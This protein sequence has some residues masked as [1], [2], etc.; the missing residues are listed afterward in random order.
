MAG[1]APTRYRYDVFL[2][3]SS[4][5]KPVVRELAEQLRAAGLR[6]WFDEWVIKPGD[7]ISVKIE[8]GLEHSAVLLFC[9]SANAIGSD[10]V[11][12]EHHAAIFRD[13]QNLERRFVPLRLDDVKPKAMLRIFAEVD[14]RPGADRELE[15]GRLLEACGVEKG[16]R[17]GEQGPAAAGAPAAGAAWEPPPRGPAQPRQASG[18]DPE[19]ADPPP[20][21]E[22]AQP[23]RAPAKPPTAP[24]SALPQHT[25]ALQLLHPGPALSVGWSPDGARLLSGGEDG[26]V[27]LWEAASGRELAV[28]E[29][30]K[31]WV[32]S[33][34]WSPDG[35]RLLS[36][37]EDGTVR[38]WEAASGRELAVLEGHKWSVWS[39]GWSPDGAR[40]LSGGADGTVRL[41]EAASGRELA[42]LEGHTEPVLS[43]GWS[44]DGGLWAAGAFGLVLLWPADL[45]A[46]PPAACD[47]EASSSYTNAKVLVVGESGAGKT[48]LT[49]RL[50][51]GTFEHSEA[52]T[53]G[54]WCTQWPLPQP[55]ATT[56]AG[57]SAAIAG[58]PQREV[59]LWDFG[60]QADQRLIHQLFLDRAALVLLL[61]DASR[62]EV[63]EGL[64]DWQTALRRSLAEPPPQLLVAARVD[65]GF[66]ASRARLEG[67]AAEQAIP[68]LETSALDG[69]GCEALQRAIHD[70]IAWDQLPRHTS[71]RLFQ[72]IKREIL[73]LRDQG[74]ALLTYKDLRE[75]LRQRV[76]TPG[77]DDAALQTVLGLLDGPG[78]LKKLDY[79]DYVLL[80][81]EWLSVF[82]QAVLRRLRQAEPQLGTLPVGAIAA[83]ELPFAADQP[84]LEAAEEQVLLAELERQL[85]ERKIC[86]RQ[87]GQLVFPSHC[88]RER[89]LSPA[90]PSPFVSYEVRGW[91]DQIHA[92]L[93][94]SLAETQVFRLQDLW[95]DAAEFS[96]LATPQAADTQ[97]LAVQLQR[98]NASEGTVTLHMAPA[99]TDAER[100]QF[101]QLIDG[102]LR[103]AAESVERRR[104]WLCPHC[105]APKGNGAVLMQKLARD[106]ERAQVVCDA[107]DR[108]FAL[109]DNLERLFADTSLRRQAEAIGQQELPELTSRR[110]GKL[111]LL[112]V[113]ARLTSANQ[114]WQE[115]NP[116][117]DDGIDMQVE[118]TNDEGNG[119]GRYLYLQLKAGPSHLRRRKDGREIF[120]IKKPRWIH[121]WTQQ[122]GPVMLVIGLPAP[123][124][125]LSSLIEENP[126][127][128]D[129]DVFRKINSMRSSIHRSRSSGYFET[130][131]FPDVRWMEISSVLQRELA[132][133]RSPEQ[134]RQIE[135]VGES[136]DMAS[137]LKWRR[138][139][140]AAAEAAP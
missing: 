35:A 64:H 117:E 21:T 100:V 89:P 92:T 63:L 18:L 44:P 60:G 37:G 119:T 139:I 123:D 96:S 9:M 22:A 140:L 134:I 135:F 124:E 53:V 13:P 50:A 16:E 98:H 75:R 12:L 30:H 14:W 82:G 54:A 109:H 29:G 81:P 127:I 69:S 104:H 72:E 116:D 45:Q 129:E 48:G 73:R 33:V 106:G 132:A 49:R 70:A 20:P 87:R 25:R 115:I 38:L 103:E 130:R 99:V 79:G 110:K 3:H 80:K 76:H 56:A 131:A 125:I 84:R 88:G 111:L 108:P 112:E 120:T 91:L 95:R 28:L 42:V 11:R 34:G 17:P 10:W 19:P 8:E 68:F 114:K 26:T 138:K 85:Q 59:W 71:P 61:F 122:P 39:V 15:W 137:V 62:D 113:G 94:V 55:A 102:H 24:P 51:T 57:S 58:E 52:S 77:L 86:L 2:S 67:F 74:E 46:S 107:C 66:R 101:A 128:R 43:V 4:A 7:P 118:F 90:L 1:T 83:A 5:D 47:G 6:V 32:R 97:A 126:H 65:A 78:V 121:T 40:L 41:W 133:G 27:R 23:A 31:D 93:V 105:H 136:L 36:G